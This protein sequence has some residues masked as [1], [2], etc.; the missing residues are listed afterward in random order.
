MLW[1]SLAA[2]I[3][4][5][6]MTLQKTRPAYW[7]ELMKFFSSPFSVSRHIDLASIL[8]QQGKK[9]EARA[10]MIS[11]AKGN[12]VNVLGSTTSPL[13]T[14]TQWEHEIDRL[15]GRYAFWQT[16]VATKPDYRD[17]YITLATLAYQLDSLQEAK[18][19]LTKALALDPNNQPS[20]QLSVFLQGK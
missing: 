7:N 15:R 20:Q 1:G 3:T 8:W 14:L 5:N 18:N 4:I 12:T 19:W 16:V 9:P 13:V 11:A 2:F 17:A 6:V 10:L